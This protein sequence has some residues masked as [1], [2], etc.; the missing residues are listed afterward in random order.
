MPQPAVLLL[1]LSGILS[2]VKVVLG[3]GLVI[4]LHELGHFLS[5][6]RNDVKVE[7]FAIGF[8]FWGAKLFTWR[9]AGGTEYVIGAFPLGGYVKMLGQA[10]VPGEE[11]ST[12]HDPRSFQAKSVWQRTEI[13]SA[14]VV[15]NFLSAFVF[16]YLA[17]LVGYHS[18][19]AT[20]GSL[21]W[22][23]LNAG[24]RSGDVIVQVADSKVETW[25]DLVL[26]YA[27]KEAGSQLP[28]T[29]ER[30]GEELQLEVPVHRD[31]MAPLN[32]P[33][34]SAAFELQLG[35][36][37]VGL[38]G[39][40]G[41]MKPGD[42]L[43][44][45]DGHPIT[46]WAE[47]QRRVRA[48]ANVEVSIVVERGGENGLEQVELRVTPQ[49]RR[50]DRV[51][52]YNLGAQPRHDAVIDYVQPGS[53][54]ALA[55]VQ[56]GDRIATV[57]GV[58]VDSWYGAWKQ[59]IWAEGAVDGEPIEFGLE[60]KAGR[61]RAVVLRPGPRP[62]WDLGTSALPEFGLAGKP[63]DSLVFGILDEGSPASRAR[64]QSGDR[65]TEVS[66]RIDRGA[67]AEEWSAEDP[68]WTLLLGVLNAADEPVLNLT[69]DRAGETL[70]FSVDLDEDPRDVQ[71]GYLGVGPVSPEILVKKG[72]IEAIGPALQAPFRV[73]KDFVNG[74]RAMA[75]RRAS[76]TMIAGPVGIIQASYTFAEKSTG[77]LLNFLALLSVNLAVIN[78]LPIPITDG[79]H[80]VF[81]MY[82]KVMGRR[83]HEQIEARFQWA[84][85]LFLLGILVFA[86]FNDL[87][88]IFGL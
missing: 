2:V 16:C 28:L 27:T 58:G 51:P 12:E 73:L 25:E 83:V 14:G 32:L 53:P 54:A 43:V 13:I 62:N 71:M 52:K 1:S 41:G 9:G 66:A 7:K 49:G 74:I 80:F 22:G 68:S 46:G 33:D 10:D 64:L 79:G 24:L 8:D 67:K 21:S 65:V 56:V 59:A 5:A 20:V 57:R 82:E 35:S 36:I 88:R 60:D 18:H 69:V 19:S 11:E 4:F 23:S 81:L 31:P 84:G 26:T 75:M 72:P 70:S 37:A 6:R 44:S 77:D 48:R 86:T 30:G 45:V 76:A 85:L 47:F 42:R 55:G 38:P 87:S 78:F 34:F 39:D 29:V 3:F 63:A 50:P 61:V 15:A 17:L 40:K